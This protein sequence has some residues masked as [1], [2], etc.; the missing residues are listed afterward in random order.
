MEAIVWQRFNYP[1]QSDVL[2]ASL[3]CRHPFNKWMLLA[4]AFKKPKG[5]SMPRK[6]VQLEHLLDGFILPFIR[7]PDGEIYYPPVPERCWSNHEFKLLS[8]GRVAFKRGREE[9]VRRYT[10]MKFLFEYHRKGMEEYLRELLGSREW[11]YSPHRSKVAARRCD[12]L[13]MIVLYDNDRRI[14]E[15]MAVC[16]Q[17]MHG[18]GAFALVDDFG[19]ILQDTTHMFLCE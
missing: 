6:T 9:I 12:P 3:D 14:V 1:S 8:D 17:L 16:L 10:V 19:R 15:P 13:K 18:Q 4:H 7:Q 11:K 5:R 2:I